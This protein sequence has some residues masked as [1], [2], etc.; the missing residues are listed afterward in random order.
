MSTS[1]NY[2]THQFLIIHPIF[3]MDHTSGLKKVEHHHQM[4]YVL[5]W[6]GKRLWTG[7]LDW[8]IKR[9]LCTM[10][11]LLLA[12]KIALQDHSPATYIMQLGW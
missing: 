8:N 5:F 1:C 11:G 4:V 2:T 7:L 3:W 12:Y 10:S 9:A 6:L